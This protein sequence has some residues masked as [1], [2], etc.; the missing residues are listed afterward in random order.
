MLV[1]EILLF[2]LIGNTAYL[3]STLAAGRILG[4]EAE[5]ARLGMGPKLFTLPLGKTRIELCLLPIVAWV[6]FQGMADTDDP[7]VGFRAM[8]PLRRVG[9]VVGSWVLP[10]LLAALLLGPAR[11]G[12]HIWVALPQLYRGFDT[13]AGIGLARA[14]IA[15][16][17]GAALGVFLAKLTAFNLF[18]PLPGLSGGL[19]LRYLLG[20]MVPAVERNQKAWSGLHLLALPVML[21]VSIKWVYVFY[22]AIFG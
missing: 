8:H 7:P 5:T 16:P 18:V 22:R 1:L 3:A 2:A 4:A 14:F 17:L 20:W 15:L 9:V 6:S 12:H 13:E 19:V 21:G 11:A 10:A